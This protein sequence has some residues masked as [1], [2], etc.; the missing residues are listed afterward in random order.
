MLKNNAIITIRKF[1]SHLPLRMAAIIMLSL[2]DL[3]LLLNISLC[4]SSIAH[5]S[6]S[7]AAISFFISGLLIQIM[8]EHG[9]R[10]EIGMRKIFGANLKNLFEL[11]LLGHLLNSF[12]A[13]L[14]CLIIYNNKK[15]IEIIS[16]IPHSYTL[17]FTDLIIIMT[18]SLIISILSSFTCSYIGDNMNI[19]RILQKR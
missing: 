17:H 6:F 3:S 10:K 15:F 14:L 9:H 16:G 13:L 2:G 12:C 11:H 1:K 8:P 5:I 4:R 19:M 18:F 7:L